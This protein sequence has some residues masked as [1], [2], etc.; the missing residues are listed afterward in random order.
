MIEV[1]DVVKVRY[2][3]GYKTPVQDYIAD[4]TVGVV[5]EIHNNQ[6]MEMMLCSV[7]FFLHPGEYYLIR[8]EWLKKVVRPA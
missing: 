6:H 7:K 5:D 4:G 1:G 3:Q 8:P 2:P